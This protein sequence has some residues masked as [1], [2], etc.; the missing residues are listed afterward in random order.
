[1]SFLKIVIIACF[2]GVLSMS[3]TAQ[4]HNVH[5]FT[6]TD[7]DGKEVILAGYKGKALLIVNTAS[8]CGYT[9]Q[10]AALEELYGI[11]KDR[12]LVVLAFPANNFGGQEP[13]TNEDIKKFC[14]F[15]FKTTFPLFAKTSVKDK[16][17]NALY[18]YLTEESP[19]KGAITWNFNKFL[20]GPDGEVVARFDKSVDPMSP[21]VVSMIEKTIPHPGGGG[22][23]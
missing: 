2:L 19:F 16:D 17:I 22:G 3:A 18:Q 8:K 23:Q 20:I 13:G 11:Y 21:E 5:S 6:M 12:G 10:Y 15:K 14:S 9:G 4:T 1:M 7:I